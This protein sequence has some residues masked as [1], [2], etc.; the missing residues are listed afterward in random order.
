VGGFVDGEI[1][2]GILKAVNRGRARRRVEQG[3]A[4][5]ISSAVGASEESFARACVPDVV[6]VDDSGE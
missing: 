1:V 6:D 2:I 4:H 3:I 5:E